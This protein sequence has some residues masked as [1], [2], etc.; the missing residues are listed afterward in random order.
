MSAP[1]SKW[2]TA[3]RQFLSLRSRYPF[4]LEGQGAEAGQE[5]R[6]RL[7]LPRQANGEQRG[8]HATTAGPH[9][10]SRGKALKLDNQKSAS[11][12]VFLDKQ[13]ENSEEP[14]HHS[15][16]IIAEEFYTFLSFSKIFKLR[17]TGDSIPVVFAV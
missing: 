8:G 13:M 2:G 12:Y 4:D 16:A 7:C 3:R 6:K 5:K 15:W 11:A 17:T 10:T 1:T 9:L 14:R